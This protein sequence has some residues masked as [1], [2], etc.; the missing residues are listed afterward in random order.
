MALYIG[1]DSSTQSLTAVVIEVTDRERRIV[2]E[3]RDPWSRVSASRKCEDLVRKV[4][5]I[6]L[7]L[8]DC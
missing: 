7:N 6:S 2:F 4:F 3:R 5:V 8:L 1:F